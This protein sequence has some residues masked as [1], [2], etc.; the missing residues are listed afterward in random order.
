MDDGGA[1]R[2]GGGAPNG[3]QEPQQYDWREWAEPA[4]VRRRVLL[5]Q[6]IAT[7]RR[8]IV[9][10]VVATVLGVLYFDNITE[11]VLRSLDAGGLK[12]VMRDESQFIQNFLTVIGLLFSILAG[13]AYSSLYTQQ[14]TIY[15]ALFQVRAQRGR[16]TLAAGPRA[17]RTPAHR[18]V[19]RPPALARARSQ[20][21]SEAK[22]LLEQ[23]TL[24]CQGRPF[25]AAVLAQFELYVSQDLRRLDLPPAYLLSSRPAE[26]PLEAIMF[27]T[28]VGVP[29]VIYETV[30]SLRQARGH[31]LGACQR[32]FPSL[33]IA[34]LY[35]LAILEL[36]AFPLLG[37]GTATVSNR[38]L[39]LQSS[40][41]GLLCGA[42]VMVLRV[43]QELRLSSGG[44]FTVDL[45]LRQMVSGLEA[46]LEQRRRAAAVPPFLSGGAAAW[47]PLA[48]EGQPPG[49]G[50]G[51]QPP[52]QYAPTGYYPPPTTRSWGGRSA[53]DAAADADWIAARA[54]LEADWPTA[55]D[56]WPWGGAPPTRAR[57]PRAAAAEP[58]AA[59]PAASAPPASPAAS[60][61]RPLE[62]QT[63]AGVE[64]EA[65]PAG[66]RWPWQRLSAL[67]GGRSAASPAGA[68]GDAAFAQHQHQQQQQQLQQQQQ[69]PR[70]RR[71][72]VG[73]ATTA[74]TA[75]A[76]VIAVFLGG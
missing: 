14:E 26:D 55:A 31:R 60:E 32:K 18:A 47:G 29:S 51:W 36:V 40:L 63:G 11:I 71:A 76:T 61:A 70:R 59:E 43:I 57:E 41:F 75:V 8:V 19:A 50:G 49:G 69:Q 39:S 38:V 68:E 20:E 64:A 6:T 65:A 10:A 4:E 25:Y 9:P 48:P 22:S 33:G 56:S 73:I 17:G 16:A 54:Y 58:A 52:Q 5:Q 34:L 3:E 2:R 27:M 12:M 37:A 53:E 46:E 42:L 13:N 1:R 67:L 74:A 21:V 35:V 44:V 30:K 28:S 24:V 15:F 23:T 66:G 7:L 72:W 45:V 62:L